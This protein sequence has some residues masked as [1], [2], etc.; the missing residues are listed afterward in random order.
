MG[1]SEG[2]C[3]AG[4]AEMSL[5]GYLRG[6]Q[7]ESQ[8]LPLRLVAMSRCYRA[9]GSGQTEE[10]GIYRCVWEMEEGVVKGGEEGAC[11]GECGR[12]ETTWVKGGGKVGGR[13][14]LSQACNVVH[15]L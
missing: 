2:V 14:G 5:G 13:E 9:E 6:R 8:E 3:L 12:V 11:T 4:T 15:V 10:R 7:M 1:P